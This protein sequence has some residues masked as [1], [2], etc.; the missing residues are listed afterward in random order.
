MNQ[1]NRW[2]QQGQMLRHPKDSCGCK[3]RAL[4]CKGYQNYYL[5]WKFLLSQIHH[6]ITADFLFNVDLIERVIIRINIPAAAA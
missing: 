3:N 6:L 1:K 2:S 5:S 4:G